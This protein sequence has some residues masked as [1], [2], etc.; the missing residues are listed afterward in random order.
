M[1]KTS[2][3]ALVIVATQFAGCSQES[4]TNQPPAAAP[5]VAVTPL[6]VSITSVAVATKF[7]AYV[8]GGTNISPPEPFHSPFGGGGG[9]PMISISSGSAFLAG[10]VSSKDEK[11]KLI[12][13]ECT[14]DNPTDKPESFKIG[15]LS[16]SVAGDR[17]SDFMAVGYGDQLCAMSDDDRRIVKETVIEV[18]PSGH[19]KLSYI[20]PL[21]SPDAKQGE[22][23]LQHSPPVTFNI[24]TA[25]TK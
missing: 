13:V 6:K 3:I 15:D 2:L 7:Q 20:F 22:I 8:G 18:S 12:E 1:K 23:I 14:I 9:M 4:K 19:R 24:D 17:A 21:F 11:T 16:L 10:E 5:P 25:T